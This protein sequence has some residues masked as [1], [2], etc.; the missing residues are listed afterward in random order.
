MYA[1][2]LYQVEDY[3]E[4]RGIPLEVAEGFN[5][6][7]VAEPYST[8]HQKFAGRLAIPYMTR[9]GVYT[10]RFR[11]VT[12][13]KPKYLSFPKVKVP[14]YNVHDLFSNSEV[15]VIT[16]GELD[17]L[18]CSALVGTPAVGCPGAS[19][20]QPHFALA[21][22]DFQTVVIAGD[23]DDAGAA[24]VDQLSEELPNSRGVVLP[25]G[26]DINSLFLESGEQGVRQVLGLE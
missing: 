8:S 9:A 1:E 26:H 3:L 12:D 18:V 23:G 13:T 10:I 22:A 5:L 15:L 4:S 16:E 6:G 17:A 14:L 24:L 19:G 21:V 11:S 7:Y 20:W 25:E 2:N